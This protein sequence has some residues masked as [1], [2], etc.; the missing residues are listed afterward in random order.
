[1]YN[2]ICTRIPCRHH[3]TLFGIIMSDA[4]NS[5]ILNNT[6]KSYNEKVVDNRG[7]GIQLWNSNSNIIKEI[8]SN[9]VDMGYF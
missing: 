4:S 9:R 6:I 2:F 1:M 8:V 5:T 7:D 3:K